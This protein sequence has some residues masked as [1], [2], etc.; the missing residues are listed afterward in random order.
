MQWQVLDAE[1]AFK[2]KL[3]PNNAF[4]R[5][6]DFDFL[7]ACPREELHQFLIGLYGEYVL[8]ASFFKYTQI[9]RAPE[10]YISDKRPL[11]SDAMLAGVWKRMRDRLRELDSSTSMVEVTEEYSAHFYDMYINKHAGKHM[12]GDRIKILLLSMPFILRDLIAP[13]VLAPGL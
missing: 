12:T 4:F 8:P 11:I 2:H 9:L 13:E 5:A 7:S 10:L 3:R 6:L 1:K